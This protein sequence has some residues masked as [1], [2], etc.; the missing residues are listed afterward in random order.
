MQPERLIV[1]SRYPEP[2]KTKTRLASALGVEGAARLQREMAEHALSRAR[3]LAA[4]RPVELEVHYEGGSAG[5]MAEWLGLRLQV[6][7]LSPILSIL[8]IVLFV[9]IVP[10]LYASET[11]PESKIAD[12]KMADHLEK[13]RKVIDESKKE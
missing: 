9:S 1:F 13:V 4:E 12:K 10:L 5:G 6:S 3:A 2:G 7:S 8:S 11:L